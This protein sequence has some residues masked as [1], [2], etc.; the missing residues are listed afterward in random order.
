[1]IEEE[2]IC[3]AKDC[4]KPVEIEAIIHHHTEKSKCNPYDDK[5]HCYFELCKKH[6]KE[7]HLKGEDK[8]ELK[9]EYYEH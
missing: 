7:L 9:D 2:K 4:W 6:Y 5:T 8:L 3:F 1:M